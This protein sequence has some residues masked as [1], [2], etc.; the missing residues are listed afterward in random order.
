MILLVVKDTG[1]LPCIVVIDPL[2]HGIKHPIIGLSLLTVCFSPQLSTFFYLC[3]VCEEKCSPDNI[4]SHL[5]SG[6]HSINYFML[7]L[8]VKLLKQCETST[9]S[10]GLSLVVTCL[11]TQVQTEPIYVCFACEDSFSQSFLQQHLDTRKHLIQTLILDVPS[12]IIGDLDPPSFSKG[13]QFLVMHDVCVKQHQF[14]AFLC[15]LC[16]TRVS[17]DECYAHLFKWEHVATFLR[18]FHPGSLNASTENAETLL[19]LAKQAA[20]IHPVSHVQVIHLDIPIWEPCTYSRVPREVDKSQVRENSLKNSSIMEAS[21]KQTSEKSPDNSETTLKKISEEVGAEITN[22]SSKESGEN[23]VPG[24]IKETLPLRKKS[25]GKEVF[26]KAISE[27]IKNEVNEKCQTIKEEMEEPTKLMGKPSEEA[28]DTCQDDGTETG[29][30]GSKTSKDVQTQLKNYMY[31]ENGR[32][33]LSSMSEESQDSRHNEHVERE[34]SHKRQRHVS[35]EDASCEE[36][37]KISGGG[38]RE[39]TTAD[40]DEQYKSSQID[41]GLDAL[42]ECHGDQHDVIYLCEC[43]SQKIPEKDIISHV[44]GF[45]H[46]KMCL[47]GVQ[48][49]PPPKG[50]HWKEGRHMAA[51]VEEDEGCGEAKL[52]DLAEDINTISKQNLQADIQKAL[53][54]QLDSRREIS[55]LTSNLSGV[56]PVGSSVTL[57]AQHKFYSGMDNYQVVDME[58]ENDSEDSEAQPS[59]VSAT[60]AVTENASKTT[61]ISPESNEDVRIIQHA[62]NTNGCLTASRSGKDASSLHMSKSGTNTLCLH[63]D[64]TGTNS[65]AE[66]TPN[67]TVGPLN[68]TT[69]SKIVGRP[70]TAETSDSTVTT[71]AKPGTA[72]CTFTAK[73][74]GSTPDTTK[75]TATV[76]KCTATTTTKLGEP[77]YKYTAATSSVPVTTAKS[78][79][80]T[81]ICTTSKLTAASTKVTGTTFTSCVT[82]SKTTSST[83]SATAS[84]PL[85]SRTGVASKAAATS[86]KAAPAPHAG[87]TVKQEATCSTVSGCKIK[88]CSENSETTFKTTVS[89]QTVVTSI[90]MTK[91]PIK[92]EYTEA[93]AKIVHMNSSLGSNAD[94]AP[95]NHKINPPAVPHGT[96]PSSV[97]SDHKNPLTEPSHIPVSKT[98]STESPPKVGLNHLIKVSC[99]GSRQ[100]YCQLCSVRL[101]WSNHVLDFNHQYNYVKMKFPGWS[102]KQSVSAEELSK[103]VTQLAEAEKGV[104]SQNIE[105]FEVNKDTYKELAAL[106]E[107]RAIEKLKVMLRQRD[108][109]VSSCTTNNTAELAFA[110]PYEASSPDDVSKQKSFKSDVETEAQVEVGPAIESPVKV[111]EPHVCADPLATDSE[112]IS[113]FDPASD[114]YQ[115]TSENRQ[116]QEKSDP[117]LPDTQKEPEGT[118]KESPSVSVGPDPVSAAAASLTKEQQNSSRPSQEAE[119]VMKGSGCGTGPGQHSESQVSLIGEITQGPSHLSK[120]LR[121]K[122]LDTGPV[123]GRGCVWECRGISL[124]ESSL[125]PFFLCESCSEML[126][127]NDICRHMVSP[128]HQ[129]KCMEKLHPFYLSKFWKCEELLQERKWELLKDVSQKISELE[130]VSKVDAQG[131]LLGQEAYVYV[132]TASFSEALK[133]VQ[134]IKKAKK[135]SICLP[136]RTPQQKDALIED[137]QSREESF[138]KEMQSFPA[139]ETDKSSDN[140]ARQT[141]KRMLEEAGVVGGSDGVKHR[142]ILTPPD[143]SSV[144]TKANSVDPSY[145]GVGTYLGPQESYSLCMQPALRL[146]IHQNTISKTQPDLRVKQAESPSSSTICPKASQTLSVVPRDEYPPT[147]KSTTV[148]SVETLVRPCTSSP[149]IQ[150]PLAAKCSSLQPISQPSPESSSDTTSVN[151]AVTP[152][153][154]SSNDHDTVPGPDRQNT[155]IEDC[156]QFKHLLALLR[157]RKSIPCKSAQYNAEITTSCPTNSSE[158]V[159]GRWDSEGVQ[160]G[161]QIGNNE[162]RWDSE[163]PVVKATVKKSPPST[164]NIGMLSTAAPAVLGYENQQVNPNANC[165]LSAINSSLEGYVTGGNF[166]F[167]ATEGEATGTM[168]PTGGTANLSDLQH[169]GSVTAQSMLGN[170]IQITQIPDYGSKSTNYNPGQIPQPQGNTDTDNTVGCQLPIKT[171]TTDKPDPTNQRFMGDYNEQDHTEVNRGTLP[172]SGDYGHLS[173]MAYVT[174]GHSG[175]LSSE[176][177]VVHKMPDTPLVYPRNLYQSGG[178]P[179]S[180][181]YPEQKGNG[182]S[183]PSFGQSLATPMPPGWL[184]LEMQQL[185]MQRQL[186]QQQRMMQQQEMIQLQQEQAMMRRPQQ[187]QVMMRQQQQVMMRQQ[188]QVM[189]R[190]WQ[191]EQAMMRQPQQEQAMMRQPQQEPLHY[192]WTH[193]FDPRHLQS[194]F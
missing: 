72:I 17:D 76:S 15:L 185:M 3:H 172:A 48:E 160:A 183:L 31:Q 137:Q 179:T 187:E 89:S 1:F 141:R 26:S 32:K 85:D 44:A 170:A 139:S 136:T 150:D 155:S 37:E 61:E 54:V 108:M 102:V 47:L 189:M 18:C 148:A 80:P 59:S 154:L 135:L 156:P 128:M 5:S 77:T 138:H 144:S 58:V 8:P 7:D 177:A 112:S 103:M 113:T 57:N 6:D 133:I 21:E 2:K 149:Q 188:Q 126:F 86:H 38:Q 16:K 127:F 66:I 82:I 164:N 64:S 104:G 50:I 191:Q 97:K 120:Y 55:S 109:Q 180:G 130:H 100:V 62:D 165:V 192:S 41:K 119:H 186:Q 45:D 56:Q 33:R 142:R 79:A 60:S 129:L 87:L 181:L 121:V 30:K 63:P 124:K 70:Q 19:D 107:H 105:A 169:R 147:R 140:E 134:N 184:S 116:Q 146:L 162:K 95:H 182:F 96:T 123:I 91:M 10:E 42:L 110:S 163:I 161:S 12:W 131:I 53:Q 125:K 75:L 36:P 49:M 65:I 14:T 29:K 151:P 78:T 69:T 122:G 118:Q 81:T 46:Q 51:L 94:V 4:L 171:I 13:R 11:S 88:N 39:V 93:S 178:Y 193:A 84:K 159:A 9:Y 83:R 92:C 74:S 117:E 111:E 174:D 71:A 153:L 52:V 23:T 175:R 98:K 166:L 152:A 157:E 22:I 194:R 43:C 90:T 28:S 20:C 68:R 24:A 35:I 145:P 190:Q 34:M 40:E 115:E 106:P 67:T 101:R 27:E 73:T 25:E 143:V 114:A 158:G 132:Q 176:A 168:L 173:N 167:K 99:E